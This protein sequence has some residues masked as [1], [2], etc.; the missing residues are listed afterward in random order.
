MNS[1]IR[2]AL[3]Q[4]GLVVLFAAVLLIPLAV[5]AYASAGHHQGGPK[6]GSTSSDATE[7]KDDTPRFQ[8]DSENPCDLPEGVSALSGDWTHGDFVSAW[9]GWAAGQKKGGVSTASVGGSI[10]AAARS[11]CGKP[12]TS[13]GHG[14]SGEAPGNSAWAHT[15]KESDKP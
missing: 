6:K 3:G 8:G 13:L 11:G 12:L 7:T 4:R 5:G 9:A 2:S 1:R 15:H 10:S 14:H